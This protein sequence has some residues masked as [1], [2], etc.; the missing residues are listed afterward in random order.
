MVG[1]FE[2]TERGEVLIRAVECCSVESISYAFIH[3]KYSEDQD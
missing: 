1:P 3:V 2:F